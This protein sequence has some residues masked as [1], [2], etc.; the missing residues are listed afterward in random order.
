MKAGKTINVLEEEI[1]LNVQRQYIALSKRFL[2]GKDHDALLQ[3]ARE[4]I[5]RLLD[6]AASDLE[7]KKLLIALAKID[8]VAI[9]R[10]IENFARQKGRLQKWATV[11]L[12]ESRMLVQSTLMGE[13]SIFVSTGLGGR[14]SCLRYFCVFIVNP[15]VELQEYQR[16][17]LREEINLAVSRANGQV[18]NV[19]YHDRLVTLTVLLPIHASLKEIFNGIIDECNI[20]G[21]FL[22][23]QMIIT[24]MKKL[25]NEDIDRFM[26]NNPPGD[27]PH[28]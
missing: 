8:E 12:Q 28:S 17:I 15:G 14:G 3:Q 20:Y 26:Q 24:N 5:D 7:K 10:A 27:A 11:A 16:D 21:N 6:P 4:N 25:T 18:E 13:E 23:E 1:D 22:H 19:E 9:Y 2:K